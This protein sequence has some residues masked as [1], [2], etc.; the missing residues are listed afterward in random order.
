MVRVKMCGI[1]SI[2][3]ALMALEEGA[4]ALGF[5]FAPS[6]RQVTPEQA[7]AIVEAL[8]PFAVTVGVFV[9]ESPSRIREIRDRCHLSVIQFH[10]SEPPEEV[11]P[12]FPRSIRAFSM[13]DAASLDHAGSYRAGALLLDAFDPLMAGGTGRTFNWEW[14]ADARRFGMPIMVSGGLTAGN[15]AE[16]VQ[17][18]YPYAVDVSSGIEEKPGKKNRAQIR[19]FLHALRSC[20]EG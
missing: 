10:G 5:V 12:F 3:D 8:P 14:A 17:H 9:N 15:V 18:L 7:K 20:P 6:P 13:K 19:A 4:D 1:T 2:G 11:N 16:A